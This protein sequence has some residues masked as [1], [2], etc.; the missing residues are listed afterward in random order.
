MSKTSAELFREA[1]EVKRQ[2]DKA[3][4]AEVARLAKREVLGYD[5]L[6]R[7]F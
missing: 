4:E 7:G 1:E 5:G 2:E 6:G 3:K